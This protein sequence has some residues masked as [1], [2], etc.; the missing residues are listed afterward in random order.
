MR[1]NKLLYI[2]G[3]MWT[4][5]KTISPILQMEYGINI[6]ESKKGKKRH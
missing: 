5:K 6:A 3:K 4:L 2:D 1:K